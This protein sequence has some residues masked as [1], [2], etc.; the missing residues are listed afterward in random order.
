MR[1]SKEL[2]AGN[3]KDNDGGMTTAKRINRDVWAFGILPETET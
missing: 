3:D 2:Y 1:A